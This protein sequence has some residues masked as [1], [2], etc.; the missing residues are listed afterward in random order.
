ML[1][2][3][4]F[5]GKHLRKQKPRQAR[6]QRPEKN[7]KNLTFSDILCHFEF[8]APSERLCHRAGKIVYAF[9]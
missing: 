5:A 1:G 2:H 8:E 7:A 6:T 3:K 9:T 4:E